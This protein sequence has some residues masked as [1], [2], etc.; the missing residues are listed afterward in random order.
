MTKTKLVTAADAGISGDEQLKIALQTIVA[1]GGVAQMRQIY[2]AVNEELHKNGYQL[3]EQGEA[4]L[5]FYVNSVGVKAGYIYPYDKKNRGWRIT[6]QGKEFLEEISPDAEQVVNIDTQTEEKIPSNVAKGA[7]F[8]LYILELLKAMYPYYVWYHQGRHKRNER[9]LDFIGDKMGDSKDEPKN[10]GVQVK[11]HR[12][13]Y[14]PTQLEWLKF[15]S[16][17]FA[18]RVEK[19]I[20]IT[21]GRLSGEQRREAGEAKVIVVEGKQ[22]VTRLAKLY[23]IPKFDFAKFEKM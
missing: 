15:L 8:E 22:E 6:P 21:T 10:I 13:K 18:R 2:T 5:R 12:E 17:C 16:G 11:F 23:K 19:A 4:S 14:T 3:S 9:G 1:N 7:A 20:F